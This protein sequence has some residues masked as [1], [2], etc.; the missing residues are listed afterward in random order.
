MKNWTDDGK[1]HYNSETNQSYTVVR[2]SFEHRGLRKYDLLIPLAMRPSLKSEHYDQAIVVAKRTIDEQIVR[3]AI[4]GDFK[5][6]NRTVNFMALKAV[7]EHL[8]NE[9][10]LVQ[11][12]AGNDVWATPELMQD[13]GPRPEEDFIN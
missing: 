2:L 12:R 9:F 3:C 13:V 11:A 5:N 4:N 8:Y 7:L 10:H 6:I 1:I